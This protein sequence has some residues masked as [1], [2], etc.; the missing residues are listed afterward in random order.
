VA[1]LAE[2][3]SEATYSGAWPGLKA[4]ERFGPLLVW[5]SAGERFSQ[6]IQGLSLK[7]HKQD[8]VYARNFAGLA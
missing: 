2:T 3:F 8:L 5:N 6:Y 1:S 7:L 4:Q